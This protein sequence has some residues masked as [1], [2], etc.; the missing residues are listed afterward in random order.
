MENVIKIV[1]K[2]VMKFVMILMIVTEGYAAGEYRPLGGRAAGLSG[3]SVALAD[4]WSAANNQAGNAFN[5]GIFCG[6]YF[7][8]RFMVSELSCKALVVSACLRPGSFSLTCLHFGS[9]IYSELKTGIGYARKFGKRFSAGIQLVY[10]RFMIADGYGSKNAI[11]CE[12]GLIFK[13]AKQIVVAF[14]CINPVPVKLITATGETLPVLYQL[15][16]SYSFTKEILVSAEI[17][18]GPEGKACA[19]IGGEW[20]F[21]GILSARAGI[22]TAP[23]RLSI[24]AG[25][26]LKRF[27]VDFASEYNQV[28]GFSP[29]VSLQFLFKK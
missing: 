1:L 9:G 3:L 6:A 16:L 17:E 28:L 14:H 21:A 24:G 29:A 8:N 15:G 11:N 19:R 4:Q 2:D 23:F 5:E 12:G 25:I 26:V 27:S 13:P 10:Y 18:K 7:E 20:R 22:A